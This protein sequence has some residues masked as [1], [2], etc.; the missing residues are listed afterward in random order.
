MKTKGYTCGYSGLVTLDEDLPHP[1][2]YISVSATAGDIVF[3]NTAGETQY[4]PFAFIGYNPIAAKRILTSATIDGVL[5]ATTAGVLGW[6]ATGLG[7]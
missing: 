5:R 2:A 4:W 1:S 3:V 7:T 6:A